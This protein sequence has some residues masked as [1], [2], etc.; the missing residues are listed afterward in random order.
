MDVFRNDGH[1]TDTALAALSR[2][3]ELAEL[4]RLEM[5]EHMAFCDLCL[6]RYTD[7]LAGA[8]LM[9]PEQSCRESVW[10]RIR[11]RTARLLTSRYATAAAAV[12]LALT[13]LWGSAGAPL[14]QSTGQTFWREAGS[15]VS[16]HIQRIPERWD[17]SLDR[18]L[19]G[20]NSLLDQMGG[21]RPHTK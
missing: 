21:D 4:T 17:H 8:E 2:G 12:T 7:F 3:E 1:L 18:L 13:L 14:R 20:V 11:M 10:R 15:A 19:S 16:E 6:Q 5:A 9:T